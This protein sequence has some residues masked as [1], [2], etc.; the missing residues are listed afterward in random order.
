MFTE[1]RSCLMR[2]YVSDRLPVFV[3]T[4]G[5]RCDGIF[6]ISV[7]RGLSELTSKYMIAAVRCLRRR[8][9]VLRNSLS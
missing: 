3:E 4:S 8:R 6:Y 1:Y 9:D 7:A 5:H 2:C